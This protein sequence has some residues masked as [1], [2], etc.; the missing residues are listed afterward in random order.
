M[1][2]LA[3]GVHAAVQ[4]HQRVGP[5]PEPGEQHLQFVAEGGPADHAQP[6]ALPEV[7]YLHDGVCG[8]HTM[9]AKERSTRWNVM[10][11]ISITT[12]VTPAE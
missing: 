4:W 12:T 1:L 7:A 2:T 9:S 8:A 10:S 6:V 5:P 11:P 3:L